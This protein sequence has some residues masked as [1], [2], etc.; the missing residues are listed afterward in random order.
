MYRIFSFFAEVCGAA[1]KLVKH[2][3]LALLRAA[4][5]WQT[6]GE[7]R[8]AVVLMRVFRRKECRRSPASRGSRGAISSMRCAASATA[9][10]ATAS[11]FLFLTALCCRNLGGQRSADVH[12]LLTQPY[13]DQQRRL[14]LLSSAASSSFSKRRALPAIPTSTT[15]GGGNSV[16]DAAALARGQARPPPALTMQHTS[17]NWEEYFGGG[18]GSGRGGGSGGGEGRQGAASTGR[19]DGRR[20]GSST[21]GGGG[22]G[23]NGGRARGRGGMRGGGGRGSRSDFGHRRGRGGASSAYGNNQGAGGYASRGRGRGRGASSF[24]GRGAARGRGRTVIGPAY[25]TDDF[26]LVEEGTGDDGSWDDY[27]DFSDD[28]GQYN[29]PRGA[30]TAYVEDLGTELKASF[31]MCCLFALHRELT[32]FPP[33]GAGFGACCSV[34]CRA[35]HY[36]RKKEKPLSLSMYL[37]AS[38]FCVPLAGKGGGSAGGPPCC[39]SRDKLCIQAAE[40]AVARPYP[41]K[42]SKLYMVSN[43]TLMAIM[44]QRDRARARVRDW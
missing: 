35:V 1:R 9:A 16:S 38:L 26:E 36:E 34:L 37:T 11:R 4:V 41:Y 28:P 19:R 10:I 15:L 31:V 12:A 30:D 6:G 27:G 25:N 24:P 32:G 40:L 5:E 21:G 3:L 44:G 33:A 20:T 8:T 23:Y 7:R 17:G 22:G 29:K 2:S 39:R 14:P 42:R 13:P 18:G 43:S